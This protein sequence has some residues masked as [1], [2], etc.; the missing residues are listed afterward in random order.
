MHTHQKGDYSTGNIDI[1]KAEDHKDIGRE[2]TCSSG[3]ATGLT[4]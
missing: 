3:E 1:A 2:N 4:A